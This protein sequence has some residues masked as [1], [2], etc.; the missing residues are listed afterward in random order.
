MHCGSPKFLTSSTIH[1][2][3]LVLFELQLLE[4]S[5]FSTQHSS[6]SKEAEEGSK[7]LHFI[8]WLQAELLKIQARAPVTQKCPV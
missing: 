6:S 3:T 2:S 7:A 5:H 4:M 1:P 8:C